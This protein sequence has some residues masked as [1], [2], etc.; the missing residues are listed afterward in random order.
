MENDYKKSLSFKNCER[1]YH[2]DIGF[3]GI[4]HEDANHGR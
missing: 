2:Q 4:A 3:I 1:V